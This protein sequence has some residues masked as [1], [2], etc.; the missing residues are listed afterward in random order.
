MKKV[1]ALCFAIICYALVPRTAIADMVDIDNSQLRELMEQGVP[2]IDLRRADEWKKTGVIEGSHLMTFFDKAGNYDAAKWQQALASTI[3]TSK[4]V[5]LICHSGVRTSI[6]G[7][8]LAKQMDTV[9]NV[10][11]GIVRWM[12]EGNSTVAAKQP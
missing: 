4:P 3:D 1:I 5:I 10:E 9:Y 6:V 11:D 7:K 12:K 2:L 8:W